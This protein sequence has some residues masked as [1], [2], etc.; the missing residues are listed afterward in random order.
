MKLS[1]VFPSVV[2]PA[3]IVAFALSP[4]V[5]AQSTATLSGVVTDPS[6]AAVPKAVITVTGIATG[7]GRTT[8][9]DGAGLYLVPS[10]PPGDYR[11]VVQSPGFGP[12][13]VPR[14]Q[15]DVDQKTTINAQ[16]SVDAQG[17]TVEVSAAATVIVADTITVGQRARP[18]YGAGVAVERTPL[19]GSD[20]ADAGWRDGPVGRFVDRAI[21]WARSQ[22]ICYGR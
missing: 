20:G 11:I 8:T 14:L 7:V 18:A 4:A 5:F 19:S 21:T 13:T 16:L 17:Q 22:F 6:G 1:K 2:V 15:L 9:S 10:L 3:G 12:Y